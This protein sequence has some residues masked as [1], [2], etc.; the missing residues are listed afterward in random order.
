MKTFA[1]ILQEQ[2]LALEFEESDLDRMAQELTWDDIAD[3]YDADELIEVSEDEHDLD[4]AISAQSRL[5]KKMAFARKKA[6]R[7]MLKGI[8]LRRASDF[9]TLKKRATNAARRSITKRL[10]R[11]R[12]KSTLSAQEK[13]RIESQ[14]RS[15]KT[16][17]N[18]LAQ[19]MIPT[20]KKLEQGRLYRK[21]K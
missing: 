19:R 10:L 8:K 4:E 21:K 11:G 16:I 5:R 1:E 3:L 6:K 18:V 15:M 9:A 2:D 17:Q 7:Q 12:D 14:V 20:I 13:D